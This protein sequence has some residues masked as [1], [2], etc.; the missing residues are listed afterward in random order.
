M[1][2]GVIILF[3]DKND[4][5][6]LM[7]LV[8]LQ[9]RHRRRR[10]WLEFFVLCKIEFSSL[11]ISRVL[12]TH[13]VCVD[14]KV[15]IIRPKRWLIE[16]WHFRAER[17]SFG[18]EFNPPHRWSALAH[19]ITFNLAKRETRAWECAWLNSSNSSSWVYNFMF[20]MDQLM[21][22]IVRLSSFVICASLNFLCASL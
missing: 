4:L 15:A 16:S 10:R 6:I 22:T 11:N 5:E 2:F 14:H 21:S 3:D 18:V 12:Y 1:E 17:R 8:T 20:L 19:A 9:L 13:L 7:E